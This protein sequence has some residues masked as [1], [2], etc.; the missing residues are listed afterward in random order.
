VTLEAILYHDKKRRRDQAPPEPPAGDTGASLLSLADAVGPSGASKNRNTSGKRT[1][2]RSTLTEHMPE[3]S[4]VSVR[5]LPG[6]EAHPAIAVECRGR[7]C[8]VEFRE[9]V[10][11]ELAPLTLIEITTGETVYLGE[12][13]SIDARRIEVRVEHCIDRARVAEIQAAW[14][15]E[16]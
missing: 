12:V 16:S 15:R 14:S 5:K 7:I 9:V 6:G 3:Q 11:P 1:G 10:P 2:K 13:Q 4:Q 8:S